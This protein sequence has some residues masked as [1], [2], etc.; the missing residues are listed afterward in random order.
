LILIVFGSYGV[1]ITFDEIH[2]ADPSKSSGKLERFAIEC[3][4]TKTKVI[5]LANPSSHKQ[6]SEPI[7]TRGNYMLLMQSTG[8]RVRTSCDWV[9]SYF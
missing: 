5:T 8:K 7:K 4:K 9:W 2:V 1:K 6:Y 3:H